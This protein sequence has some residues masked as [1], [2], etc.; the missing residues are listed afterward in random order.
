[1]RNIHRPVRFTIGFGLICA[2]LFI[3]LILLFENFMSARVAFCLVIWVY[4][5]AYGVFI[6]RRFAFRRGRMIIP[7][8][9][10]FGMMFIIPL[11]PAFILLSAGFLSWI[12]S[13]VCFKRSWF[14]ML[15][16][17]LI[18]SGGGIALAAVFRP[19]SL[20]TWAGL[21][22]RKSDAFNEARKQAEHLMAL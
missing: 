9:I 22:P 20:L 4:L 18:F 8:L 21:Q 7:L 3:P 2:L 10:L 13:D 19:H 11:I 14:A 15:L 6:C 5:A 17:E 16:M 12:R 1:M